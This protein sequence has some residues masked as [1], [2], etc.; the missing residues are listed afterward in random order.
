MKQQTGR[1]KTQTLAIADLTVMN[2]IRLGHLEKSVLTRA[3]SL[4]E[5]FVRRESAMDIPL[6]NGLTF[7]FLQAS[8]QLNS[9]HKEQLTTYFGD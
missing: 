7:G 9:F 1:N 8:I 4:F 3:T 5:A 6:D 2:R